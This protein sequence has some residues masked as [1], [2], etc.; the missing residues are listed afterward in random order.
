ML[1][2]YNT[3]INFC[4]MLRMPLNN[5]VNPKFL[6]FCFI[7]ATLICHETVEFEGNDN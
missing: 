3:M 6:I 5:M 1:T 7:T 4:Y 2:D